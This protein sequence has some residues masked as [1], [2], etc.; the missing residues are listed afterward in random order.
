MFFAFASVNAKV[1]DNKWIPYGLATTSN[2]AHQFFLFNALERFP[3]IKKKAD[4]AL[5]WIDSSFNGRFR[6]CNRLI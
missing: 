2:Y 3:A 6:R 1:F 5:R 4:W